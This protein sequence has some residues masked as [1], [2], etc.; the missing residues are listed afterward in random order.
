[1]CVCV[2]TSSHCSYVFVCACVCASLCV[3]DFNTNMWRESKES[4]QYWWLFQLLPFPSTG[5]IDLRVLS[6]GDPKVR[7]N[8]SSHPVIFPD[9]VHLNALITSRFLPNQSNLK[10]L[11][12]TM[13]K[14]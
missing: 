1:M 7:A 9:K 8:T 2:C 11:L 13:V 10:E 6:E 4:R 3:S 5:H 14:N 12:K